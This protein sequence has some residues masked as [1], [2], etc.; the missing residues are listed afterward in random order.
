M[1]V[2]DVGCGVGGPARQISSFADCRVLGLNNNAYQVERARKH[3]EDAGLQDKVSFIKGDFMQMPFPDNSFD[4]VYVIEA[5]LHAP[6]LTGVHPEIYR[7]LKPGGT[8]A[9]YEWVMTPR[10]QPSDPVHRAIRLRIEH[11]DAI[12]RLA[13]QADA[14]AAMCAVGFTLIR[15]DDLADKGDTVPWWSPL[16][17]GW[18]YAHTLRDALTMLRVA[19]MGRLCMIAF[20]KGLELMRFVSW[21][22]SESGR[23]FGGCGDEFGGGWSDGH[24]FAHAFDGGEERG[25]FG[26]EP[27]F[28]GAYFATLIC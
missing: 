5:T 27:L 22:H 9:L 10:F 7:V 2:L 28:F 14:E 8:V 18:R 24:L 12:P 1:K 19:R 17:G 20:L 3:T 16:S 4:A 11:G 21:R 26:V 6:S 13:M 23:V 15:A 25:G